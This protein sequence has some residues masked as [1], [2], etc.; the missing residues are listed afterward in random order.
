M[1]FK[2]CGVIQPGSIKNGVVSLLVYITG[3]LTLL[4]MAAVALALLVGSKIPE[5]VVR[6]VDS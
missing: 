5:Y 1:R 4:A 6:K 2:S 3:L